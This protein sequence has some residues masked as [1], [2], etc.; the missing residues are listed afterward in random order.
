M[1]ETSLGVTT[2][3][4]RNSKTFMTLPATYLSTTRTVKTKSTYKELSIG[5]AES[6]TIGI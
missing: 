4:P 5:I 1:P 2:L 3:T 6:S